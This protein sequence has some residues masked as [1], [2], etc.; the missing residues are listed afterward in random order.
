MRE[1]KIFLEIRNHIQVLSS[2]FSL[3]TYYDA[4]VE[5]C[6]LRVSMMCAALRALW[7]S[8]RDNDNGDYRRVRKCLLDQLLCLEWPYD[9]LKK[10]GM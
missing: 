7:K 8:A 5:V 9:W 3:L 1:K 2:I 6:N 4:L 10:D